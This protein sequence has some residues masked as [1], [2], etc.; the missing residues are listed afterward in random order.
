MDYR[1]GETNTGGSDGCLNFNDEDNK[2]LPECL[3]EFDTVTEY[4]KHCS[5][6]SLADYV[7]IQ[8]E[9]VTGIA[10]T[11]HINADPFANGSLLKSFRD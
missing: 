7:V 11:G 9:A 10:A 2:G 4:R 8:A 3:V 6:I 1:F 5:K